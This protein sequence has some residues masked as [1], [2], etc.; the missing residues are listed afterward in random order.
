MLGDA[1]LTGANVYNLVWLLGEEYQRLARRLI[2]RLGSQ[3]AQP[4]RNVMVDVE[5]ASGRRRLRI[6]VLANGAV[7]GQP[8]WLLL[9]L[10]LGPVAKPPASYASCR[11]WAFT[12][13]RVTC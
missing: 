13:S 7:D 6:D 2:A 10:D 12:C 5:Q 9:L 4:V 3:Q 1:T 8:R 11:P